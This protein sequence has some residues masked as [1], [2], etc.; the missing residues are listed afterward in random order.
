MSETQMH[1][2]TSF[3][4]G[5]LSGRMAGRVDLRQYKTGLSRCFNAT[6]GPRGE[7]QRRQGSQLVTAWQEQAGDAQ[8]V[9]FQAATDANYALLFTPNRLR[10]A[11]ENGFIQ[12]ADLTSPFASNLDQLDWAQTADMMVLTHPDVPPQVIKRTGARTFVLEPF[13][14]RDVPYQG[15]EWRPGLTLFKRGS[16]LYISGAAPF[17]SDHIGRAIRIKTGNR[18]YIGKIENAPGRSVIRV[19]FDPALN[20]QQPPNRVDSIDE[21]RMGA[22][23]GNNQPA[24]VTFHEDRLVFAATRSH[25]QSFWLSESSD[26]ASF[27][28]CLADGTIEATHAIWGSLNDRQV[29]AIVWLVSMGRK[30]VAGTSAGLWIIQPASEIDVLSPRSTQAYRQAANSTSALRPLITHNSLLFAS[31]SGLSLHSTAMGQF[32]SDMQA[33]E[34]SIEAEHLMAKGVTH[35]AVQT[36]PSNLIWLRTTEG[37]LIGFSY[38]PE[39]GLIA[40]HQHRLGGNA[41]LL[42]LTALATSQGDD[43]WLLVQ[44]GTFLCLERITG[45][46]TGI[47]LDAHQPVRRLNL[48][49]QGLVIRPGLVGLRRT[50]GRLNL[51]HQG[52]VI[53]PGLVNQQPPL[54]TEVP[55]YQGQAS[56]QDGQQGFEFVSEGETMDLD[57]GLPG[58]TQQGQA[59][60]PVAVWF[61]LFN[62]GAF[63]YGP[64]G[65]QFRSAAVWD[66]G[67]APRSADVNERFWGTSWQRGTRL[68]WRS[69]GTEPLNLLALGVEVAS[70]D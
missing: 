62:S 23:W 21:W 19:S 65:Q 39:Q 18:W 11:D 44:R 34:I 17:S 30:L 41:A 45:A 56:Q 1:S 14:F 3:A 51:M 66:D 28:P 60:H 35:M 57:A 63:Y 67:T 52:P 42:A 37:Q 68:G 16:S 25:P 33:E 38:Q 27:R 36:A 61:R 12:N 13:E 32:S 58:A 4:R 9:P 40:W 10:V 20:P 46:V 47:Y 6:I 26:Y 48:I 29:N 64:G 5:E 22:F 2:Q 53:G 49:H 8:L 15:N 50:T 43:L 59:R 70:S 54:A 55:L 69:K 31:R 24:H 7:W